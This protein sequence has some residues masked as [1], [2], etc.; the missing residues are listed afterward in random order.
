MTKINSDKMNII[1]TY[2]RKE[3]LSIISPFDNQRM[4]KRNWACCHLKQVAHI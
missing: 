2:F 1:G 3:E 4:G